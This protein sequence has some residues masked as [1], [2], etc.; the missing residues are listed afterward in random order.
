MSAPRYRRVLLTGF[1]GSGKSTVGRILAERIG[2]DFADFDEVVAEEAGLDIGTIFRELGEAR[3]R[4]MEA[5]VG[6]RL[7]SRSE[8]VLAS[9]GGWA[10]VPGRLEGLDPG[11]FSVW[12]RVSPEVAVE[13]IS[14]VAAEAPRPLLEGPDPLDTARRLLADREEWYAR[15]RLTLDS[16]GADPGALAAEIV[17][18]L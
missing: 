3:F 17:R 5:R 7:L 18:H 11:T 2:W 16:D 14:S 9:G 12:L 1:M 4:E 8:V 10:A 13:R 6:D 15:S